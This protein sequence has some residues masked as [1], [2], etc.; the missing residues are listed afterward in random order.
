MVIPFTTADD[1]D[2]T[3]EELDIPAPNPCDVYL[4]VLSNCTGTYCHGGGEFFPNHNTQPAMGLNLS[5][6][7]ADPNDPHG[8]LD[9]IQLT[10]VG[11]M[12]VEAADPSNAGGTP[13]TQPRNFP[14]GMAI[15]APGASAASYLMYKVLMRP[16]T[17][18]ST[19]AAVYIDPTVPDL[20]DER[21]QPNAGQATADDLAT[22]MF[23]QP[24][25]DPQRA[26]EPTSD[27]LA[28]N[29]TWAERR[30]IR[31][32]IDDGAPACPCSNPKL[33]GD[34][35]YVCPSSGGDAGVDAGDAGGD[36]ATDATADTPADAGTD[37]ADASD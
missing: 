6:A 21:G 5:F 11:H 30:K 23:G 14:M 29:L 2:V 34:G 18:G 27:K 12:S 9:P 37:G 20:H 10:A 33:V 31:R 36:A 26:L 15:I 28:Q 8:F 16:P 7:A 1:D 19:P 13:T 24:M 3:V 35:D 4:N 32:W 22:R 25:P 17:L